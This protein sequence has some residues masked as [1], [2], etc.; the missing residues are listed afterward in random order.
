MAEPESIKA[1]GPGAET[2]CAQLNETALRSE[3]GFWREMIESRSDA[4]PLD[5]V[6]RMHFALALAEQRLAELF[7]GQAG[8]APANVIHLAVKRRNRR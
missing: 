4:L 8:G 7:R 6:E 1:A 3:I 5:A 2:R